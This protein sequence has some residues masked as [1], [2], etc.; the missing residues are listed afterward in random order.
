MRSEVA[1]AL[2]LGFCAVAVSVS[3]SGDENR[4]GKRDTREV[5]VAPPDPVD[6]VWSLWSEWTPC[7][8]C[9]KIQHRSRSVEVFGQFGGKPCQGQPIGE[10]Q[11]C[12]I[13]AVC[14]QALPP[15]CSSTEFTCESGACIKLRLSCNGDYDCEDGSDE[16]CEPVRKPCGTKLYDTNEQ[17]RTAG[18]GINI[19]GMEPRINPFNN[20]YFNGMCNKVKNTNNNEYNRLPWNVGLLNYETIAEETVSKEIYEDTYT[21]LR[22]LMTE[23]K[24][25]VSAGLNLKFTPTEKSMA[26]SN[27]TVSG[28]VGLDAE[29]DRTQMIKEVSEYSTIKNKSF[30]RVNGH[31]QLST[32]RMR[33]RDLQVAGEFLEHVKSLPLEYE[34]GQYFSFLE[35]YGTHYTRNGKSGGEYQLIYVLNQDTIK[36]KKLTE[37]K[38]Q[39]CIKVGISG[40]FDTN[41]GIGGDAHIR[42]GY[43]KDTVNK[44]TDE[45]EGKAL[46]DKVIT[47]VR[48]GTLETAVAMRTQIM[49]E[50]L[51]DINT[52]QNWARTV[53]DA[54]ALL[55]SEPEP[56]Q[57]LIP[58]SMPDANTRR[59]N[60]QRATQEYEAEYSVCKCKPCHNGGT[61]ALL[62][63]K[64]LCLCLPQFEGLACQDAKA[65]NNKNTKTPVESVPQEGN[66]SCWAAWSGC[67]GGKRIRTR[68]CNTQGLSG[69]TCSGDTVAEDYC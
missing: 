17:G 31:V 25:T 6:C 41:I 2:L 1:A 33:S 4:T 24:L 54:P 21:L 45:K 20:D 11:A 29:Y 48:G 19:L 65:D 22:E 37:R 7:N 32:Y 64:C 52:Y 36:D 57:T 58:L 56:I 62:D 27:T 34:K 30:M 18:Y 43:C 49:K 3:V 16:D 66:W 68:S 8:S 59:L 38:L 60:M 12:T 26:K 61:L 40:N 28:G 51:V 10:Q 67:S 5:K 55:S 44:N 42:P 13:D 50:G 47:V 15:E 53:G 69:A 35:D 9:T 23:T 63:G 46:V 14:E 39:D